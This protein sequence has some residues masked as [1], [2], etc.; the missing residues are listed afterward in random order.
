MSSHDLS[1]ILND[2][3]TRRIGYTILFLVFGVFGSWASFAPLDSAA[4]APGIVMIKSY[5]KTVQR[6]SS[7]RWW[8]QRST[9][10]AYE[11]RAG[12]AKC[13]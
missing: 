13:R 7:K 12:A 6:A 10:S 5:R 11:P 2:C 1:V 8:T 3:Q 9:A 4:L